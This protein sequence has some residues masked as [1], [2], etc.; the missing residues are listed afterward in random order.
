MLAKWYSRGVLGNPSRKHHIARQD[1]VARAVFFGIHGKTHG[2]VG[3]KH[4][5]FSPKQTSD[6]I[7]IHLAA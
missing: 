3:R 6:R 7:V 1:G 2:G 5:F 4:N